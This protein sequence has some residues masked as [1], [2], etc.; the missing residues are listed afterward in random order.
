MLQNEMGLTGVSFRFDSEGN[1]TVT[2]ETASAVHNHK[3]GLGSWKMGSTD[4]RLPQQLSY[5]NPMDATTVRTAGYCAWTAA[6]K[7]STTLLSMFN[8]N[9]I[10]TIEYELDG[11]N[12]T[13]TIKGQKETV[14]KGIR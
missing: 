12:L 9:S 10:E 6:G 1:C 11:D 4:R 14:L 3:Y 13:M 5:P 8:V 2:M 7:L